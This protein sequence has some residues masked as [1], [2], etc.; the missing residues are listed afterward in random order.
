MEVSKKNAPWALSL[1]LFLELKQLT[2]ASPAARP[3][4][5]AATRSR[6]GGSGGLEAS[7]GSEETAEE[8][9]EA[10]F[11]SPPT[12]PLP[13][14]GKKRVKSERERERRAA[15]DDSGEGSCSPELFLFAL[16]L[17]RFLALSLFLCTVFWSSSSLSLSRAKLETRKTLEKERGR[18]T[19][20]QSKLSFDHRSIDLQKQI[21]TMA[22]PVIV[23]GVGTA[24]SLE[25]VLDVAAGEREKENG[26]RVKEMRVKQRARIDSMAPSRRLSLSLSLSLAPRP[27]PRLTPLFVFLK[28][29]N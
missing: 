7:R 13:R 28:K 14:R 6:G 11:F 9:F 1:S 23:G 4:K 15:N 25:D 19:R 20:W 24:L 16:S 2:A 17:S 21:E 8:V 18:Q 10:A 22:A 5:K 3:E 27:R 29:K 12:R 26:E